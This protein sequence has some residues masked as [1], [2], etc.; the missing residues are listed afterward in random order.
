M[1]EG[2][3]EKTSQK[4]R[5]MRKSLC[6]HET[7]GLSSSIPRSRNTDTRKHTQSRLIPKE[8]SIMWASEPT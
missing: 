4:E 1:M 5:R 8:S 2:E 3:K 7:G 6:A